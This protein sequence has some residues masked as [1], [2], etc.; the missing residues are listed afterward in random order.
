MAGDEKVRPFAH[1][2]C[3]SKVPSDGAFWKDCHQSA[4]A[5]GFCFWGIAVSRIGSGVSAVARTA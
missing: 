1:A 5:N 4:V 2:F 3:L